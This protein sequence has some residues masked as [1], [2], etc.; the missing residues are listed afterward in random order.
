[1]TDYMFKSYA[2]TAVGEYYLDPTALADIAGYPA[3]TSVADGVLFG[4]E[5][6]EYEGSYPTTLATQ[7]ADKNA[8]EAAVLDTDGTDST[9]SLPNG[10]DATAGTALVYAAGQVAQL[11][12]DAAAVNAEIGNMTTAVQNLLAAD[13]DGQVDLADYV[14]IT[15]LPD[16]KYL[17][18]AIDRGDGTTGTLR[19]STL[20]SGAGAPGVDLAASI[21][22][23]T[24]VVDDVTGNY[25]GGAGTVV[26]TITN[27]PTITRQ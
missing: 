24:I 20:H 17:Y 12:V 10:V 19:A 13:N 5:G 26:V 27:K 23:N 4:V 21:L 14:L 16:A 6:T 9:I 22:K 1:M 2:E 3:T 15:A 25:T 7:T 11:A 8:I 18:N